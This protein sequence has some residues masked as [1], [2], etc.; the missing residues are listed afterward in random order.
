MAAERYTAAF[1]AKVEK[2]SPTECWPWLGYTRPSG[3]G[4]TQLDCQPIHAHRKAWI[5]T[6]GPIRSDLCVN[7]RCDNARCCNP[8]HMYLGTRADNMIDLWAET[9]PDERGQRAHRTALTPIQLGE[10]Y[11][12]RKRG[13][14]IK[15]CAEKF[16][17]HIAT[18]CRHITNMRRE[19]L[20]RLKSDR[21][22]RNSR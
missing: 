18:V 13:A 19:K 11:E 9:P 17:V 22:S 5:L 3:H 4:L 1:W 21:L 6:H 14:K 12:M 10:L 15:E 2:G 8:A 7:H 20:A 16:G